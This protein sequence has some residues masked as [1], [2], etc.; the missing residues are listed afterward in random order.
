M[1]MD[2]EK[3][4]DI[5]K[6]TEKDAILLSLF[7]ILLYQSGYF[8]IFFLVP[9]QF[10]RNKKGF[11]PMIQAVIMVIIMTL[12]ISVIKT[13]RLE[14]F[15]L[16]SIMIISEVLL[17]IIMLLGFLYINYDWPGNPRMLKKLLIAT[18]GAFFIGIPALLIY[19]STVFQNF[20]KS[21]IAA[22]L[23]IM[24]RAFSE[25]KS[26]EAADF[27]EMLKTVDVETV[28][29][30]IHNNLLTR[31]TDC[32]DSTMWLHERYLQA[33]ECNPSSMKIY[34][35]QMRYKHTWC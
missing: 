9:L 17:L 8:F 14:T 20:Y 7:S 34:S 29:Y 30:M 5:L 2:I 4:P 16:R 25:T 33:E 24:S 23:E 6:K 22:V 35:S 13:N 26:S 27:A 18:T 19:N 11:M 1:E 21:Q 32:T 12:I 15:A 28:Y 10:L 3:F 31:R